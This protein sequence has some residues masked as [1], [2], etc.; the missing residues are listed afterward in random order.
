VPCCVAH[1]ITKLTTM[2]T[3]EVRGGGVH[4]VQHDDAVSGG[5]APAS[6]PRLHRNDGDLP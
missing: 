5:A 4:V 2:G 1:D 6:T 3:V